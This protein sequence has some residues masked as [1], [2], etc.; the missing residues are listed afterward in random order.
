MKFTVLA[1]TAATASAAKFW[2]PKKTISM[3]DWGFGSA[4]GTGSSQPTNMIQPKVG[5]GQHSWG[6]Q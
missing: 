6:G 4:P 5:S 1:L 3:E 2:A